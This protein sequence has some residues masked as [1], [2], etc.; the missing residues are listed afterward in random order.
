MSNLEAL[1][2]VD[3]IT[4]WVKRLTGSGFGFSEASLEGL[5]LHQVIV[6]KSG[7]SRGGEWLD[8]R[9]E[10]D[11]KKCDT[12]LIGKCHDEKKIKS[13]NN[14]ISTAKVHSVSVRK[15]WFICIFWPF[16]VW[17]ILRRS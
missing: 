4:G 1:W 15:P 17:V 9:N 10:D 5:C 8:P 12:T 13:N 3:V 2:M 11:S 14:N 7:S 16:K 6:F